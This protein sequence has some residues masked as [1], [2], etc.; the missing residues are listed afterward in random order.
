MKD[1]FCEIEYDALAKTYKRIY[2]A[3]AQVCK[4]QYM[5]VGEQFDDLLEIGKSLCEL[6]ELLLKHENK[7]NEM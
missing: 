7:T 3:Y 1:G 5:F 6:Q 4:Y 2:E